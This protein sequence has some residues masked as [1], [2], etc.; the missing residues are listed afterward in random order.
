MVPARRVSVVVNYF[1]IALLCGALTLACSTGQKVR[2]MFGGELPV[3]VTVDDDANDNSAIAVDMVV[4]YDNKLLDDLLKMPATDW[5]TKRDQ[6]KKDYGD[7][8]DITKWEWVPGQIVPSFS[9]PYHTGARKVLLFAD[10]RTQGEHRA[11]VDPQQPFRLVLGENDLAM[12]T[13]K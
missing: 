11:A 7:S 9:I 4:V 12:E 13:P 5:F 6:L 3:Q 8:L 1:P 2:S 10:Y